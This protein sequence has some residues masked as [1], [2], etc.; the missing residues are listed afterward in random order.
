MPWDAIFG[1]AN[2]YAMLC[3][4]VL[5]FAPKRERFIAPLFYAG[6]GL[7]VLAYSILIVGL[8]TGLIDGGG[9]GSGGIP[10]LTT[11]AGV[12]AL[13]DTKGGATIGWIHYLAFDLF[14]GIWVARNADRHG[15][16]RIVQIPVLFFV[17]MAGPLGLVL[18]LVLRLTGKAPP[19]DSTVP[20]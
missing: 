13:F 2:L 14:V 20:S 9:G 1:Y 6:V 4:L 12:Q 19:E 18:Y 17:F 15:Y 11:L 5:A 16:R 3:W 8:L 7:L 10:D